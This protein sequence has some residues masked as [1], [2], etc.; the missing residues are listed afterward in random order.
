MQLLA[1]LLAR[2]TAISQLNE[3]DPRG[4]WY[5]PDF[6]KAMVDRYGFQKYPKTLEEYNVQTGATFVAGKMGDTVIDSYTIFQGGLV[7]DTRSCTDNSEKI[8]NDITEWFSGLTG[9]NPAGDKISRKFYLSQLSFRSDIKLDALNPKLQS[10]ASRLTSSVSQ[11]GKQKTEFETTG[12]SFQFDSQRGLRLALPL[13]IE[14][15]EGVPFEENKYFS[16]APLPTDEHISFLN[17]FELALK[18]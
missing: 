18:S 13:R 2:V 16:A 8:L 7:V 5:L 14:R 9:A 1:V 3:W 12:I 15:L 17:E 10:L 4:R 6:I 11:Y